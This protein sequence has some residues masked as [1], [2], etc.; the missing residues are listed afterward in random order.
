MRFERNI[1]T[2]GSGEGSFFL[3]IPKDIAKYMKF[4]S[5]TGV[6]INVEEGK[7]GKFLAIWRQDEDKSIVEN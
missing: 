5:N 4:E 7:H 2:M 3:V 6:I 1:K